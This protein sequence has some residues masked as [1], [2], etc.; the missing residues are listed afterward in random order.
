M[1]VIGLL[2]TEE[3]ANELQ[4]IAKVCTVNDRI[5]FLVKYDRLKQ[6]VKNQE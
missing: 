4:F 3:E 2:S 1:I 5:R 6:A